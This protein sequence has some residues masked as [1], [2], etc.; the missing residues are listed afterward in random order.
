MVMDKQNKTKATQTCVNLSKACTCSILVNTHKCVCCVLSLFYSWG[1]WG[2]REVTWVAQG[3]RV[4]ITNI[5]AFVLFCWSGFHARYRAGR[6]HSKGE[7]NLGLS[8]LRLSNLGDLSGCSG[9]GGDVS[10]WGTEKKNIILDREGWGLT[11][12]ILGNLQARRWEL[13][14]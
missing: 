8:R 7:G 13:W 1:N 5:Q 9:P 6:E 10:S 3:G 12:S 2:F 14:I 4:G 11:G